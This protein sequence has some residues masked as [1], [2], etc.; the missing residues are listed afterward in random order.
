[1]STDEELVRG[2]AGSHGEE[3]VRDLYRSYAGEI[4]GFAFER[5]A[6]RQ[7]AEEVVQDTFTRAWRNARRFDSARGSARTWLYAI[8]RNAVIDKERRRRVRPALATRP[9]EERA[10]AEEPIEQSLRRW[11]VRAAL[12]ELKPEHREVLALAYFQGL[13]LREVAEQIGV[14]LGTVKRRAS[15]ALRALRLRLEE[16][17]VL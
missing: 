7:L 17:G 12:A 15:Y 10:D 9:L 8:A 16:D 2:L 3:A 1:M 13:T 11:Q 6:D 5:L 14:P 4:F